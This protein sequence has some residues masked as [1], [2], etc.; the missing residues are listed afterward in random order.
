MSHYKKK[1]KKLK[2]IKNSIKTAICVCKELTINSIGKMKFLK[3]AIFIRYVLTNMID[4]YV[5][6]G[7]ELVS[8]S[9]FSQNVL[10]KKTIL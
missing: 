8:R 3:Q 10:I 2:I 6:K 4:R 1:K 9:R 5:L 7:L